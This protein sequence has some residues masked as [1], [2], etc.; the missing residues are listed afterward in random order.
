M[1]YRLFVVVLFFC[2]ATSCQYFE[3]EKISSETIYEEEIK[4][5]EW[6][7]VDRYPSFPA[8]ESIL[9]KPAQKECFIN[10]VNSHLYQAISHQDLVAI[11][12]V[13]DTVKVKFEIG[14]SAQLSIIEI[15]MDSV[16]KNDFPDLEMLIRKSIDSIKP[17][18]PAYKRGV[19]VNTQFTLPIVVQSN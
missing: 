11:R 18:S 5:I 3:T 16:L 9:E 13:Y 8:C 2:V 6:K 17:L 14:S 7:E 10:T 4:T 19:P 15:E 1:A 12:E